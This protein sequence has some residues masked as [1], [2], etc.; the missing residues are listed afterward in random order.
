MV[1]LQ[2][3]KIEKGKE[4]KRKEIFLRTLVSS[5]RPL[6]FQGCYY[7]ALLYGYMCHISL[8]KSN[9]LLQGHGFRSDIFEK[10]ADLKPRFVRFPGKHEFM[11]L[12]TWLYLGQVIIYNFHLNYI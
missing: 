6:F 1:I 8:F 7:Y 9:L 3:D 5:I 10:L 2:V 12:Y 11:C 4:K